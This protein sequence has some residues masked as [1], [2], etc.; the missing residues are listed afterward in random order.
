[1]RRLRC[2][3]LVLALLIGIGVAVVPETTQASARAFNPKGGCV[4]RE[5]NGITHRYEIVVHWENLTW[6]QAD[7]LASQ[8]KYKGVKGY[9]A[10]ITNGAEDWCVR[11]MM[12]QSK[13]P[14]VDATGAW[15][16]GHDLSKRGEWRW[17]NGPEKG[18]LVQR[19]FF[20][21]H[22]NQPDNNPTERCLGYMYREGWVAGNNYP[23]T[24]VLTDG[25]FRD[26]MKR[27]IVEY[28]ARG[29][30]LR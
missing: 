26:K 10:T 11:T 3:M 22:T 18:S 29:T 12:L 21:W 6:F 5:S 23:C 9:L 27:Y 2:I 24:E 8:R 13:I 1:M 4:W 19:R 14:A 20:L 25:F 7:Q 16:G 15:L 17:T 30:V 28:T